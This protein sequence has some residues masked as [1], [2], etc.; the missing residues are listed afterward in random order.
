ME[1][2]LKGE[3]VAKRRLP[4]PLEPEEVRAVLAIP[5]RKVPTGLRNRTMVALM[6]ESGLRVSEVVSLR[7]RD[8]A[9]KRDRLRIIDG[10]GGD[11]TVYL[12]DGG[13][14]RLTEWLAVRETI[15]PD[16]AY[17]FPQIRS[18]AYRKPGERLDAKER[19][20]R[21]ST[22]YVRSLTA[23]LGRQAGVPR[24]T[25]PHAFRHTAAT[26]MIEDGFELPQVQLTLGHANVATT[27]VYLHVSNPRLAERMK[28]YEPDGIE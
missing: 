2:Q 17:V 5:N 3:P 14:A 27:S 9:K 28:R 16:S 1:A 6:A 8:V 23:R 4:Q 18:T 22:S 12:S 19:G 11:R 15:T 26:R 20:T 25:N 10:K 21:L 13:T 24:R 7:M